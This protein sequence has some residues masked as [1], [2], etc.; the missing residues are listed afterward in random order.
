M[1]NRLIALYL[2]MKELGVEPDT[3]TLDSR[4]AMQ[5]AVYLGQQAGIDLGYRFGWYILGPYSADLTRDYFALA[6][7]AESFQ[8]DRQLRDEVVHKLGTVRPLLDK[9]EDF[10]LGREDWLELL[11]SLHYLR[12]VSGYSHEDSIAAM[13]STEKK[14]LVPYAEMAAARLQQARLLA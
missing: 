6:T 3:K 9:P 13:Q 2:V 4:K 11:A 10:P 7:S 8:V 12:R 1:E 14:R 5:K